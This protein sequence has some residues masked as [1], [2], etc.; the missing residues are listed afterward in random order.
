[1]LHR[2]PLLRNKSILKYYIYRSRLALFLS[3]HSNSQ[4]WLIPFGYTYDVLPKNYNDHVRFN[5]KIIDR[6]LRYEYTN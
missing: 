5:Y 3:I 1:M 6:N 4:C 2:E